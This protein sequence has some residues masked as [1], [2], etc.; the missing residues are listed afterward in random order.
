MF[1][2]SFKL[3]KKK[4]GVFTAVL[5]IAAIAIVGVF[6]LNSNPAVFASGIKP[7]TNGENNEQRVEFI[8]SFGHIVNTEPVNVIEMVI[9]TEFN[10]DYKGYNEYQK[11]LGFD[12]EKYSGKRVKRYSYQITNYNT[13]ITDKLY[14]RILVFDDKIIG[15]DVCLEKEDGFTHSLTDRGETQIISEDQSDAKQTM[16]VGEKA[17]PTD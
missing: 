14:A 5:V 12:L 11:Q 8:Q 7:E 9:P 17:Y 4:I 16:V 2:Y 6:S 1:I 10:E 3:T 15:G 13:G